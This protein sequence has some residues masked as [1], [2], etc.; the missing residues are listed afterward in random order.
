MMVRVALVSF[1]HV[2]AQGYANQVKE[3]P[4]AEAVC[5]WDDMPDRGRPPAEKLG[6]PFSDDYDAVLQRDDVDAIVLNAE[7]SKHTDLISKAVTAGKHCFTEKALTLTTAD[8]DALVEQVNA[9][10]I[11]FMISL[12]SRTRSQTL[13]IKQALDNGLLGQVTMMRSRV[14]HSAALDQWF[15][16]GSAWFVDAELAGGGA[17]FDLGCH[18]TDVMRWLMGQPKSVVAQITNLSGNYDIDDNSVVAIEFEGGALGILDTAF[19]HRAGPNITELYGTEG[20]LIAGAPGAPLMLRST[21]LRPG[22]I[23][24]WIAPENLPPALPSPL[25]QWVNAIERGEP[26]TITVEDGRNLTELLE[27]AYVSAREGRRVVL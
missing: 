1:A 9:A 3:N 14:A 22:D 25:E 4:E 6:V 19:V 26:M 8:A 5:V 20:C 2:H 21:K 27:A 16:G 23:D 12:P 7:T 18:T 24:G 11:K 13:F 15:G 10:G 17:L